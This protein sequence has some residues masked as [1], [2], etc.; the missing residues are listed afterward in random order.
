GLMI[1]GIVTNKNKVGPA[2]LA[3][4]RARFASTTRSS[5]N[6]IISLMK[7][8]PDVR[9]CLRAAAVPLLVAV[10]N[11][12][13]WPE[14]LHARYAAQIGARIAVYVT[15]HSPCETAPHQL[16]ADML[17]LFASAR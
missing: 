15:G 8:V 10:G 11:H 7:R 12:D 9:P 16:A 17:R 2:R 3:F 13:L 1:W 4:V 14:R 6:D 5:V